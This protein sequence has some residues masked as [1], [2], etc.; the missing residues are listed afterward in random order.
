MN[1]RVLLCADL[2]R[3]GLDVASLVAAV[4]A[5]GAEGRAVP[6][7]CAHPHQIGREAQGAQALV[8]ATCHLWQAEGEVQR[9]ARSAGVSPLALQV[10]PLARICQGDADPLG[11]AEAVLA[12]AVA[13]ARAF[14]GARPE[15]LRP[16]LPPRGQRVSRRA[17]ISPP[18][19]V[20]R[21]TPT[22]HRGRCAAERGCRHCTQ[23]CPHQALYE[24]GGAIRLRRE[25]CTSCGVCVTACPHGA[26]EM[27]GWAPSEVAAQV[28]ALL[29]RGGGRGI[30]YVCPQAPPPDGPWL[31]V[32][33]PCA[34]AVSVAALLAPLARGAPAVAALHCGPSCRSGQRALVEERVRFCR[35]L[36]AALGDDPE[37]VALV[38]AAAE[39]VMPPLSRGPGTV[40]AGPLPPL[41]GAGA[42]AAAVLELAA[43]RPLALSHPGAPMGLVE[44]D[45]QACTAC[46]T[47]AGAC[48]TGAIAYR[49]EGEDVALA[50]DPRLCIACGQCLEVCPERE[51]GAI[52]LRRGVDTARLQAGPQEAMEDRLLLCR[53][54]GGPV[55]PRRV[56]ERVTAALG[57]QLASRRLA[58]LCTECRGL[59]F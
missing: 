9:Y 46:G 44:I 59:P 16:S 5:L 10:V 55:A 28:S 43:G 58:E 54:C 27:P 8:V 52:S 6:D 1:V 57:P 15:N 29:E 22:L 18:S 50:F 3:H 20:Y 33:V 40:V 30:A 48:P 17:F 31:T 26:L 36:L 4:E 37:R 45:R 21:P 32:P 34:G 19:L 49:E 7:L 24:E 25:A 2:G 53:R 13:R 35:A 42:G 38:E 12:G 41:A 47:C 39:P 11:K 51:R 23:Q 56:V 14:P